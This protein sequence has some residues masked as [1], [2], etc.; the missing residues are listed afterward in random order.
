M[1]RQEMVNTIRLLK[2]R[3]QSATALGKR[4]IQK[5]LHEIVAQ[6]ERLG[7]NYHF[8]EYTIETTA[9][10]TCGYREAKDFLQVVA[11]AL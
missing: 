1:D 9:E 10:C 3:W 4:A 2:E 8:A 5:N 6:Y 11:F 7:G